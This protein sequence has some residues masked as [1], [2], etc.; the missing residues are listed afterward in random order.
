[1]PIA[2]VLN[3]LRIRRQVW[4]S[5]RWSHIAGDES[6]CDER[7]VT[8]RWFV[9]MARKLVDVGSRLFN[10]C[11]YGAYTQVSRVATHAKAS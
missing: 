6:S 3:T 1:M 5:T 11:Q 8:F 4:R 7:R 9:S 10:V 2:A